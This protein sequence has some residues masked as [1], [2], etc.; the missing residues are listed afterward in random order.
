MLTK[1]TMDLERI[2][3]ITNAPGVSGSEKAV[4]RIMKEALTGYADAFDYDNQGSLICIK[5]GSGGG[6]RVMLSAHTDEIGFIVRKIEPSGIIRFMSPNRWW[7]HTLLGQEVRIHTEEN[8]DIIGMIGTHFPDEDTGRERLRTM[9][10][11]YIDTGVR[12]RDN[13]LALGIVPGNTI[14]LNVTFKEMPDP[15]VMM[16]R[17]WD[18]RIGVNIITDV[19]QQLK[20][21]SHAC[22]LFV[23]GTVQE[24]VGYRGGRTCGYKVHPDISITVDV[25]LCDD[26]PG[27]E[28][29]G[30]TLKGGVAI[31]H[32]D[33]K[34]LGNQ[35]LSKFIQDAAKDL[36]YPV[37]IIVQNYGGGEAYE[38]HRLYDGIVTI[39]LSVP[40]LYILSPRSLVHKSRYI[41]TVNTLVEVIKRLTNEDVQ[42]F[43]ESRR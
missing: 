16:A 12:G 11:L 7:T 21:E 1:E 8:G 37:D 33:S 43:K 10:E 42:R 23:C 25:A 6:P 29:E 30:K 26:Y 31:R 27:C 36:D 41:A 22:D 35:A 39:C 19:M 28:P 2:A 3:A 4:T 18:D 40:S 14:T 5:H 17:A 38:I 24:E 32:Y 13:V 34:V 15:D 9:E 20:D